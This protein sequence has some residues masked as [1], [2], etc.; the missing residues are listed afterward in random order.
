VSCV[1]HWPPLWGSSV[2]TTVQVVGCVCTFIGGKVKPGKDLTEVLNRKMPPSGQRRGAHTS[3]A[4][5]EI[6]VG[7]DPPGLAA[8]P[9]PRQWGAG[10]HPAPA[11]PA[12]PRLGAAPPDWLL[13]VTAAR[14]TPAGSESA[15]P[16]RPRRRSRTGSSVAAPAGPAAPESRSDAGRTQT[17]WRE[18][19][20]SGGR[21]RRPGTPAAA[22]GGAPAFPGRPAFVPEPPAQGSYCLC[23]RPGCSGPRAGRG[24]RNEHAALGGVQGGAGP[25][26]PRSRAQGRRS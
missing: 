19:A 22:E 14:S 25:R 17:G 20:P 13:A 21:G 6:G 24:G 23:C 5:H 18:L 3:C 8:E 1:G 2:S 9:R 10:P 12:P 11:V 15:E 7:H 4:G 26:G 16:E